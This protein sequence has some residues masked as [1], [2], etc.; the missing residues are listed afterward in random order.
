MKRP[1]RDVISI[2][3]KGVTTSS[4]SHGHSDTNTEWRTETSH[5]SSLFVDGI[6]WS[7][8]T[9]GLEVRTKWDDT[10]RTAVLQTHILSSWELFA[11]WDVAS[12]MVQSLMMRNERLTVR[13]HASGNEYTDSGH[14]RKSVGGKHVWVTVSHMEGF[15]YKEPQGVEYK[16]SMKAICPGYTL[17]SCTYQTEK[18]S[19]VMRIVMSRRYVSH[20]CHAYSLP[21][22]CSK[23]FWSNESTD[24][25]EDVYFPMS[26]DLSSGVSPIVKT[27]SRKYFA[28]LMNACIYWNDCMN[29]SRPARDQ[30]PCLLT[31][32]LTMS[33]SDAWMPWSP[34]D[35]LPD[36]MEMV[37]ARNGYLSTSTLVSST[38]RLTE[39]GDDGWRDF[40]LT[41]TYNMSTHRAAVG[42][43]EFVE[44]V[45]HMGLLGRASFLNCAQHGVMRFTITINLSTL[46]ETKYRHGDLK[47][48]PPLHPLYDALSSAISSDE[49][50]DKHDLVANI[51]DLTTCGP[52]NSAG[53][54]TKIH[55]VDVFNSNIRVL[56]VHELGHCLGL[57]HLFASSCDE[58][59]STSTMDYNVEED[60]SI[61]YGASDDVD[62]IREL[63]VD[64]AESM[65]ESRRP[66]RSTSV[67]I[68][69]TDHQVNQNLI[70]ASINPHFIGV[71][72]RI[73]Q[74]LR[75]KGSRKVD[76]DVGGRG[77]V[78]GCLRSPDE[79]DTSKAVSFVHASIAAFKYH[80][81]HFVKLHLEAAKC[82]YFYENISFDTRFALANELGRITVEGVVTSVCDG[83]YGTAGRLL[84]HMLSCLSI[85]LAKSVL[86][87]VD[88]ADAAHI[89]DLFKS[90]SQL[91]RKGEVCCVTRALFDARVQL[92]IKGFEGLPLALVMEKHMLA[93]S[94]VNYPIWGVIPPECH[95]YDHSERQSLVPLLTSLRESLSDGVASCVSFIKNTTTP[96]PPK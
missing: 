42:T 81:L 92:L 5:D 40:P 95:T 76:L 1:S 37:S 71:V 70:R 47:M 20:A 48:M 36:V 35:S 96:H 62:R 13:D 25:G 90:F 43:C 68:A 61:G 26:F 60:V 69:Q 86:E 6:R 30:G 65:A 66:I 28:V 88:E 72:K 85:E 57:R 53:S 12:T 51:V 74:F 46:S 24:M 10:D 80:P 55:D 11:P 58:N 16:W 52:K 29:R 41:K 4:G 34:S 19:H 44:S 73:A 93:Q 2:K 18:G 33:G 3:S 77:F 83:K 67:R 22:T 64:I 23:F 89:R 59:G 32:A 79:N 7:S 45:Q 75:C 38:G 78:E 17:G 15:E 14:V 82:V 8:Q 50:K 94:V 63:Y 39:G 84:D 49:M 54:E 91:F 21:S 9:G 27:S 87:C 56:L 31:P